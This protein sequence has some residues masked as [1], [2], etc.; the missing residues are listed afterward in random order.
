MLNKSA[1]QNPLTPKPSIKASANKIIKALITKRKRPK[2]TM[3]IGMVN[4]TKMGFTM[5]L[6]MART[7]ATM[8]AAPNPLTATPG[9]KLA[10]NTT[11]TAVMRRRMMRFMI[12][13]LIGLRCLIYLNKCLLEKAYDIT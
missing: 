7:M 3:V 9:K 12:L 4:T 13:Y 6:S 2:V 8:I 5:A 1:I 10:N 11:S